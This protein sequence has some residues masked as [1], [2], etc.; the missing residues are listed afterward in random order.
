MRRKNILIS[1]VTFALALFIVTVETKN[2]NNTKKNKI[3]QTHKEEPQTRLNVFDENKFIQI[4]EN[5]TDIVLASPSI[6]EEIESQTNEQ[7][8]ENNKNENENEKPIY[9]QLSEEERYI[10]E[11][12]VMG[13]SRDESYRGQILVAQ[14]I[15]N[16]CIKEDVMPSVIKSKYKYSGWDDNPNESVK[17]AVSEVFDNGY[18][19]TEEFILYF[20]APKYC[21]SSWHESQRYILTEGG[22]RF[23]AEN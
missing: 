14:C 8:E 13:E 15:L 7:E 16:A 5:E 9:F 10:V 18:K 22:H 21:S 19:E 20:Y 17:K 11:C 6:E 23:F 2:I 3:K 4:K 1:L 12:I